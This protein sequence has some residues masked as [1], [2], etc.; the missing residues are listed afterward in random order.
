MDDYQDEHSRYQK[1]DGGGMIDFG[2]WLAEQLKQAGMTRKELAKRAGVSVP[3]I[4]Y[5]IKG[6]RT[7]RL[8]TL[9]VILKVFNKRIEITDI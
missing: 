5:Y 1:A 2:E 4:R 6:E 7:P 3:I 9:Q 8:D